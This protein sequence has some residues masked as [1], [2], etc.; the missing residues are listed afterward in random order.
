[1]AAEAKRKYKRNPESW[2]AI[3]KRASGRYQ[4]SY[5]APDGKRYNAP[6]TFDSIEDARAF[7]AAQRV[8]IQRGAW[9]SPAAIAAEAE[10]EAKRA[11]SERF[12]T[13]AATYIAQRANT[14]G[15]PL[16]PK[17]RIEYERQLRT[18]LAV[19]ADDRL[20]DITPARVRAWHASRA[21][22]APTA[23]GKDARLL[24]GILNTAVADGIL[25]RN[26]VEARYGRTK[27]GRK[28][29]APTADELAVILDTIPSRFRLAVLLAAY[30]SL[31][32]GEWRAL[33]R[34]DLTIADG[35]VF[36]SV[37]RAAQYLNGHG[38]EVGPPKSEE[39][40]RIVPLPKWM[41]SQVESHLSEHV[42][43]FPESLVI[44]PE[45]RT[46]YLTDRAWT[47]AW[48]LARDAAGVRNVVREHDLRHFAGTMHARSGAT[49]AETKRLLGHSTHAAAMEYQYATDDRMT[50]LADRMPMLPTAPKRVA[51]V[52]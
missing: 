29:R 25:T 21:K 30:G 31:R 34:S 4:A 44:A 43:A 23:A 32:L 39:G 14:K 10:A 9:K 33:R 13:Y 52:G 7:L 51:R 2:G 46:P 1:M 3:R 36:V 17:T 35:R 27:T 49:I 40:V 19:F 47:R 37:E 38:W 41:T 48:D 22:T 45:G 5:P 20:T 50:E 15:Q 18:G 8:D 12:A 26:P 11:D 16:R 24:H 28:F 42:G 6:H